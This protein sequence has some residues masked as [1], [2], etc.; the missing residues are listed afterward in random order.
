MRNMILCPFRFFLLPPIF[1]LLI[2]SFFH[3]K[4]GY[5]DAFFSN[6]HTVPIAGAHF[7]LMDGACH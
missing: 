5:K 6:Y 2:I 1:L 4:L 7:L 3:S